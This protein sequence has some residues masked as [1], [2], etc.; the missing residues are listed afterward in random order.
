MQRKIGNAV[1]IEGRPRKGISDIGGLSIIEVKTILKG[2]FAVRF[3][4][5]VR[6]D[7]SS[8]SYHVKRAIKEYLNKYYPKGAISNIR[9]KEEA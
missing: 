8:N 3:D 6:D 4:A 2:E 7:E 1:I 5:V 9:F